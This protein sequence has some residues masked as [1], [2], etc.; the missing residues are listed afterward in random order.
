MDESAFDRNIRRLMFGPRANPWVLPGQTTEGVPE[1]RRP[2][3]FYDKY[4][5]LA[6]VPVKIDEYIWGEERD[7]A[8]AMMFARSALEDLLRYGPVSEMVTEWGIDSW[9]KWLAIA[10]VPV[11]EYFKVDRH[12]L[13]EKWF[14]NWSPHLLSGMKMPVWNYTPGEPIMSPV[15]ALEAWVAKRAVETRT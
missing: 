11:A 12:T 2:M 6:S 9:Q 13:Y 1:D 4:Q 14:D 8:T 7:V 5:F 15:A 10:V 3:P